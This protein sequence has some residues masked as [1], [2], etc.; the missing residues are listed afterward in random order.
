MAQDLERG[1]EEEKEGG[2]LGRWE[3]GRGEGGREIS[4]RK[5]KRHIMHKFY[6]ATREVTVHC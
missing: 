2:R 3:G 6:S 1:E 4:I 5:F